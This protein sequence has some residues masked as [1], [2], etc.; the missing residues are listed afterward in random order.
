[1]SLYLLKDDNGTDHFYIQKGDEVPV[2]L[3][4]RTVK[5]MQG[6]KI[7]YLTLPIYKGMLQAKLV[8]CQAVSEKAN[9]TAFKQSALKSI[10]ESYNQC[11]GGTKSEYIAAE[12]KVKLSIFVLGGIIHSTLDIEGI[13]DN[14][15]NETDFKGLNYSL[16][17][18]FVATFPRGRGKF[19]LLGEVMYK[20][21]GVEGTH[22]KRYN[23][24]EDIYTS[25][26]TN[27]DLG[28]I[29]LNTMLRY[30]LIDAAIKPYIGLGVGNNFMVSQKSNQVI[31][32]YSGLY[33]SR[34][35]RK[36]IADLRKHE[37][38]LLV[39]LGVEVKRMSAELRLENGNGF[40]PFSGVASKTYSFG[41]QL[42]YMLR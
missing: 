16:G 19:S 14:A 5:Q 32:N 4:N 7:G 8:E 9:K 29:S 25:T 31:H 10:V 42:G 40:S 6:G 12:E 18:S 2:E 17:T 24:S 37:Q 34:R 3:I 28:Y 20:S 38:S 41:F 27:F 33:D 15:L 21:Y 11:M 35:E 30:R 23:N 39:G 26:K 22:I 1:M 13:S 36:P